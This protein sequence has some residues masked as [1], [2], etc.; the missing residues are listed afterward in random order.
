MTHFVPEPLSGELMK[1]HHAERHGIKAWGRRFVEVDDSLGCLFVYHNYKE[2]E[3][4]APSKILPLNEL[5]RVKARD[6]GNAF[7]LRYRPKIHRAKPS[8]PRASDD[9]GSRQPTPDVETLILACESAEERSQWVRGLHWRMA[10]QFE[11]TACSLQLER[12]LL[13]RY[14]GSFVGISCANWEGNA[15]GV[16]VLDVAD[17]GLAAEVGVGAGDILLAVDGCACFSHWHA[18]RLID[19]AARTAPTVELLIARGR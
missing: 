19:G 12:C 8:S 1:K 5:L 16:E 17:G 7:E 6:S 13:E 9:D 10:R 4:R 2:W 18:I 3:R 15:I 14:E 11:G